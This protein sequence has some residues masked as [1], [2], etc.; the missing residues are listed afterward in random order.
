MKPTAPRPPDADPNPY[1][2]PAKPIDGP[3]LP[4]PIL[5]WLPWGLLVAVITSLMV[6]TLRP[7]AWAFVTSRGL[8]YLPSDDPHVPTAEFLALATWTAC[9]AVA[10]AAAIQSIALLIAQR[11]RLG[12]TL[13]ALATLTIGLAICRLGAWH[14]VWKAYK[15]IHLPA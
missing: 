8:K 7:V 9:V 11:Q 14:L 10:L 13:I 3:W 5:R 2:S 12:W 15:I 6:L 1:Q 4:A